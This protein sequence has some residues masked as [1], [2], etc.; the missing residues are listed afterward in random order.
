LPR[1][2]ILVQS[3]SPTWRKEKRSLTPASSSLT[4]I[5]TLDK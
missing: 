1:L 5:P 4:S 3:L 2:V